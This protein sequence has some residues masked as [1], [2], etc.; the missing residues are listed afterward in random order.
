MAESKRSKI[1][2]VLIISAA[3]IAGLFSL[4]VVIFCNPMVL[5][6]MVSFDIVNE[7]GSDLWITPIGMW[8]G[9]RRYG[10]LPR[11]R[12]RYPPC[13]P[14][15]QHC[16]IPV[17][18]GQ[19]L[20]ITYDCDD[21]NFRHILLRDISGIIYIVD[22]DKKGTARYCCG[23]QKKEYVIPPLEDLQKAPDELASC[24]RGENVSYSGAVDYPSKASVPNGK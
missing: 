3:V 18:A 1:K 19:R 12:D 17:K 21:I 11:F 15:G 4:F 6:F 8:E 9:N 24:T 2:W 5:M 20:R 22:T 13:I 23:P 7:S 16:D 14:H 10:P